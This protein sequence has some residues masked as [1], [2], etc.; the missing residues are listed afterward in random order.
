MMKSRN[1][2][3]LYVLYSFFSISRVLVFCFLPS[4]AFSQTLGGNAA[5][6]FLKL[7]T[8]P[9]LTAMGGTNVSY[10]PKDVSL[11]ANNPALLSEELNSQ[12]SAS[13]NAFLGGIK[14]Y[15]L[16]GA[17]HSKAL[18]T[19]L[20]GHLYYMDYGS[21]RATDAAGNVLGSF[22]PVDFVA[23]V[24]VAKKY[25]ER[26]TY[27][28]SVKFIHSSYPPYSSSALAVDIGLL[29]TDSARNFTAGFVAKNMG[30]QLKSFAGT[31]EDL[32]FDLEVG[33]SKRLRKAPLGFSFTAHHLHRLN[34][35]YNDAAFNADNGFSS[36]TL[37]GK[38]FNHFILA[39]HVFLSQ[40]LEAIVGYNHLQRQELSVPN[41]AN[42]LA[43]FS[44]GVHVQ[45]SKLRL[46]LAR[47]TYQRGVSY[48]QLGITVQLNK[49][50]GS[51][52][53]KSFAIFRVHQ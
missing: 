11:A 7:P 53:K 3:N 41:S 52:G 9:L 23:Q 21:I 49:L 40:N 26:W 32:P 5:Y 10:N 33:V 39:A 30:T 15:A 29:Y 36:A 20:G 12:I 1:R 47:S 44:A 17:Y 8:S 2:K 34:L 48:T 37:A 19:T 46:Q 28:A 35:S 38:I 18:N 25:L 31:T 14:T 6:N 42:G 24:S 45:F 27:G 13:F 43:G 51:V 4:L 16:T 50:G 22:R